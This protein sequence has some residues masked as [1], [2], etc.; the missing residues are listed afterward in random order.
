VAANVSL[1]EALPAHINKMERVDTQKSEIQLGG[2]QRCRKIR[3]PSQP[4][5][6]PIRGIDLRRRAYVIMEAWHKGDKM[7]N[8]NV[9]RAAARAGIKKPK[10]LT[11]KECSARAAACRK[12][13]KE[14][15]SE[16]HQL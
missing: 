15:G 3:W 4:F 8:G 1:G 9:F 11:A 5:S 2:E 10:S 12:L 16:A 13:I 14:M 6:P 7:T